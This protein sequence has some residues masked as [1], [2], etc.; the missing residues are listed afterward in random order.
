M[1]KKVLVYIDKSRYEM[2]VDNSVFDDYKLEACTRLVE[3]LFTENH[4]DVTPFMFCEDVTTSKKKPK[5]CIKFGTYNTYKVI[6]NAGYYE[7]A[8]KLRKIFY[9]EHNLDLATESIQSQL[10]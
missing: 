8:E 10:K 5:A 2:E 9:K 3:K 1:I 4:Y 7:L 6:I